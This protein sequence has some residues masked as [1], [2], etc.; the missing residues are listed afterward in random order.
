MRARESQ[1]CVL[2]LLSIRRPGC[3]REEIPQFTVGTSGANE[4]RE[5]SG[6]GSGSSPLL[7]TLPAKDR[8]ALRRLKGNRGLLA[9]GGTVGPSFHPGTRRRKIRSYRGSTFGLARLATFGFVPELFVVEEELFS[10][11]EDEFSAAVNAL[12]NLVLEFH[13]ELLPSAR[14]SQAMDGDYLQLPPGQD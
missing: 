6:T 3:R 7:E 14:D 1:T 8:P 5:M 4:W 10:G 12:Q 2:Q 13:G 9:A 11:R